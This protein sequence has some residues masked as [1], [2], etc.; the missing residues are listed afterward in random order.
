MS[1]ER[2]AGIA[3]G[4]TV[5]IAGFLPIMA[6]VSLF[7]AV[8]SI[9]DHFKDDPSAS[10]KVPWMVTAPGLAIALIAPFAG[11][12]VDKFG[13][14]HLVV[15]STFFYAILGCAPFFLTSLN[16]VFA[17]RLLLGVSEAAILTTLNTLIGDYWEEG[18]RRHVLALQ[19]A[20]GPLLASGLILTSG[21]LTAI[22]WNAVFLV[23][24]I[25]F[26]VFGAMLA[27]LYEPT[28]D[29]TARR[30]L[31]IDGAPIRS[32]FPGKA[33]AVI[34][35]G[36][37][38][39]SLLYYVF[40][41]NGG[42]AFREVGIQSSQELGRITFIPSLFVIAG[43]G[44][45]WLTGK[46]GS[47]LQIVI[48]LALTGAGLLL[49]GLG[50]NWQWMVVGLCLQQAGSG[51][52]VPTLIS[53]AQTKLPFEHRGRGMGVW[54]ACFFL[55]QFV[56]PPIVALIRNGAGSM[57]GAFAIAGAVALVGMLIAL[58]FRARRSAAPAITVPA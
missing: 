33:I 44:I 26:P 37:L 48:F 47:I 57:R 36:T 45:F 13:R 20:V 7:P 41:V 58:V 35:G 21:Y 11:Y 53:W 54:S 51:M 38:F 32:G 27:C 3:Q 40:I 18:G 19:G 22:R 28:S 55:G 16:A 34:G 25:A 2:R 49:M 29:A 43:A 30:M 56:S 12:L 39:C 23:Y 5:V 42:L 52:T 50:P 17:S 15:W 31:G 14:R 4:L 10:W 46:L 1:G 24:L 9:I 6:I 8:P